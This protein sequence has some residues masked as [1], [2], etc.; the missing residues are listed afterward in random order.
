MGR[1]VAW[2][3]LHNRSARHPPPQSSVDYWSD[4]DYINIGGLRSSGRLVGGSSTRVDRLGIFVSVFVMMY[5]HYP[6][7][8]K[9]GALQVANAL[10]LSG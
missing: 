8:L 9:S 2:F 3:R 6:Y 1:C 7:E 4:V 5:S 10:A